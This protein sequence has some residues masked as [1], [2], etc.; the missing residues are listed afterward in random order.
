MKKFIVKMVKSN[1]KSG[2]CFIG[3]NKSD[4]FSVEDKNNAAVFDKYEAIRFV[5]FFQNKWSG[6]YNF[7]P[8]NIFMEEV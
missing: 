4:G 3:P 2:K 5:E 1:S 8:E 7:N 6:F